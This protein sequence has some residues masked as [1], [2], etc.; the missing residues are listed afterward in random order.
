MDQVFI[1]GLEVDAVIGAY[2]WERD[3]RQ[4]LVLD[5]DMAW[6]I[7][8]AAD[9]DDLKLALDYAAVSQRVLDYVGNS[10]FELVE[11]LAER[12]ATLVMDEF[13]VPWLRLSIN[14]PG[15]VSQALGGVGVVIERGRRGA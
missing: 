10:S 6:D 9:S 8:P 5:L 1:R 14:K 7:R 2:D 4:R 12:L 11:T 3:I 15:A 13:A